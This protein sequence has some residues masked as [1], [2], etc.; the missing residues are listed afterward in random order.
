MLQTPDSRYFMTGRKVVWCL[1][2][3]PSVNHYTVA[4]LKTDLS[5]VNTTK[6]TGLNASFK[7]KLYSTTLVKLGGGNLRFL[8][9]PSLPS[10]PLNPARSGE[11]CKLPAGSGAESPSCNRIWCI[12]ALKSDLWWQQ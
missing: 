4:P 12:S 3:P 9:S 11:R 8:P 6:K 1:M 5:E 7:M 10:L 2:V